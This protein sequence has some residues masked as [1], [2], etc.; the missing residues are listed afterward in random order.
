MYS[1]GKVRRRL[2]LLML[3]LNMT[4]AITPKKLLIRAELKGIMV[5]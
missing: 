3:E 2:L 1:K 4:L 5:T